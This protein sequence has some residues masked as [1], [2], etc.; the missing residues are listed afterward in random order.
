MIELLSPNC[1][2]I[3]NMYEKEFEGL[4]T[5]TISEKELI[6]TRETLIRRIGQTLNNDDKEFPVSLNSGNPHWNLYPFP[7]IKDFPSV[8]WRLFNI[9]KIKRENPDKHTKEFQKLNN[10]FS[11]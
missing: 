9:K 5:I 3:K 6:K 4:T 8:K 1:I 2:D 7:K 10:H 11:K